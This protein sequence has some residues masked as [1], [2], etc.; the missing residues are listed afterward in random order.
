[1]L[2]V[3][4]EMMFYVNLCRYFSKTK[5]NCTRIRTVNPPILLSLRPKRIKY[6]GRRLALRSNFMAMAG[7]ENYMARKEL[8]VKNTL[9]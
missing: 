6:K 7:L 8:I 4:I 3:L 9:K 5:D 1:M 2:I